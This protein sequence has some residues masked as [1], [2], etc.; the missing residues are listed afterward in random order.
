MSAV[1]PVVPAINDTEIEAILEAAYAAGA[2]EAGYIILRLPLELKELYREWLATSFPDRADRA[3][4]LLQSMFGGKDY[5]S[6][7]G[8]RQRGSGPYADMIAN[9]FKIATQR[10]GLNQRGKYRLRTDLFE[11]P[12]RPGG[13]MPLI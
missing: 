6:S 13:Q 11:R 1:A 9:R 8:I 2:R 12:V 7:F 4:S 10:L 5:V 3:I